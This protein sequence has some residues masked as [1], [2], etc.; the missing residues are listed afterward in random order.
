M[1]SGVAKEDRAHGDDKM[2]CFTCH[3]SW[4]TSCGG[5]HLPIEANWKTRMHHFEGEE[6]RNFATYNP[7][8]A[9]DEM[10]Q[11]GRHQ[12]TKPGEPGPNGEARGIITPVRSTSALVLSSTNINRERIYDAAA[13]DFVGGLFEPGLRAA[14]FRTRCGAPRPSSAA[15]AT[16]RR[17]TITMRSWRSSTCSAPI[18]SILSV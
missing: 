5:C 6:T 17:P 10:F 3:L 14:F 11:L 2:T 12:L 1:G 9:R 7:Q 18:S 4:T 13:A 16:C 8:V 15:T